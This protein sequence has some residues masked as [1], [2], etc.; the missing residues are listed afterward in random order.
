[1]MMQAETDTETFFLAR[2]RMQDKYMDHPKSK[3]SDEEQEMDLLGKYF[4]FPLF[5][6]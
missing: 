1:M 3:S 4:G 2:R 5:W 6:L